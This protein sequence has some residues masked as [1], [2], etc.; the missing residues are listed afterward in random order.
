[1]HVSSM[2]NMQ[3]C[4]DRYVLGTEL[5]QAERVTVLDIGA[6]DVNG[7]Y[8][9]IFSDPR[10]DYVGAD[11]EAGPNISIVLD[12]PY[13]LPLA[14][15]SMDIVL[16]GQM[17]EHCE[18][19]WLAFAEMVRVLK[20]GGF[21]FLIAPS[22]GPIHR[23]PVDCYRF[24]PDA[25]AALAKYAGCALV[26]VW[27]DERPAWHDLVGVFSRE[28]RERIATT[29]VEAL[30]GSPQAVERG[31]PEEEAT[32]GDRPY[33]QA[34]ADLHGRLTPQR[35]IEVGV[36]EGHSLA[37]AECEA[38][39]VDPFPQITVTLPTTARVVT[40]TSDDYFDVTPPDQP[41]DLAFIDGMHLFEF[42]L[43]D[44]MNLERRMSPYGMIVIDDILPNH[45]AQA[46]RQ[47]KTKVWTGDVWKLAACLAERRPD[48]TLT[49][50]DTHPTGLLLITGLDPKTAVLWGLYNRLLKGGPTREAPPVEFVERGIARPST[51]E[52]FEPLVETLKSAR[53]KRLKVRAVQAALKTLNLHG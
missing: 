14:D 2:E 43:R 38:V 49:Y 33:R 27:R 4:H 41:F 15:Q 19:F 44:F 42:A 36:R 32:K 21:I 9:T 17:L 1:M 53:A 26:D 7:S 29:P 28:P 24:Y 46:E 12:D 18:F 11:L 8:R 52:S 5:G 47:R 30:K 25:Y 39:G 40:M 35:Y 23:Y 34:L 51:A 48:L 6:A 22:A 45:A 31:T 16:S 10:F 3:R 13:V 37:L 50:L 20:P